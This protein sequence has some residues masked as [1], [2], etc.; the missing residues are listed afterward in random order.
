MI[1][2]YHLI[3]RLLIL[4]CMGSMV[5]AYTQATT[6][7]ISTDTLVTLPDSIHPFHRKTGGVLNYLLVDNFDNPALA[8]SLKSYQ[9]QASYGHHLPGSTNNRNYGQIMLDMFFGRTQG[10]HGLAYRLEMG[11]AGNANSV[12]QR[13][14]YSF[15]CL[16]RKNVSIRIGGGIG[17]TMQQ[18]IHHGFATGDKIDHRYGFI[19]LSQDIYHHYPGTAFQLNRLHWNAGV[20][21][22]IFDGYLNFYNANQLLVNSQFIGTPKTYFAGFGLNALY[23]VNLKFMQIIPSFQFN[24]FSPEMYITQGGVFLASNTSKGGGGGV[25]Y[26]NNNI[27]GISG[28]FAWN[29]FLRITTQVQLPFSDIRFTYPISNFQLTISYKINDVGKY[30]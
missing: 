16:N 8:G 30:E 18:Y 29:D 25:S 7:S 14:D 28:L 24:Y 1:T 13:I 19:F 9:A 4:I 23:K 2:P 20:Q 6:D 15:E 17:F 5:N 22:R 26:N 10:R 11:H 21:I 12:Y 3:K 27:L